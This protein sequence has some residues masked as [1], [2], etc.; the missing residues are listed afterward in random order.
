MDGMKSFKSVQHTFLAAG[1]GMVAVAETLK[2]A[3]QTTINVTMQGDQGF[4]IGK[5]VFTLINF[6]QTGSYIFSTINVSDITGTSTSKTIEN[7]ELAAGNGVHMSAFTVDGIRMTFENGAYQ[8]GFEP[9]VNMQFTLGL[10]AELQAILAA[11][12]IFT[13]MGATYVIG[14]F[15]NDKGVFKRLARGARKAL[16]MEARS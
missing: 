11:G 4:A 10:P 8:A 7:I 9:S 5:H 16:K 1:A 6:K 14:N 3:V 13:A 2:G 12:I 15:L